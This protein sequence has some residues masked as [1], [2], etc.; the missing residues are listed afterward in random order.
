M[1]SV[2][3]HLLNYSVV[4]T[5]IKNVVIQALKETD[6]LA[7]HVSFRKFSVDEGELHLD[8]FASGCSLSST[9][10]LF[11]AGFFRRSITKNAVYKCKNGGNCEMDMYMRRKC[12]ECRLRKCKQMGMLAECMYTGICII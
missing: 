12:Q 10:L 3:A 4:N 8:D 9:S 5:S 2:W 11:C 6:G 7:Q 1:S